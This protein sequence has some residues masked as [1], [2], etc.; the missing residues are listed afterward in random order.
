MVIRWSGER[1]ARF[2]TLSSY[3]HLHA[4]STISLVSWPHLKLSQRV[5]PSTLC[6]LTFSRYLSVTVSWG[7]SRSLPRKGICICHITPILHHRHW[8]PIQQRIEY[9][10]LLNTFKVPQRSA[11]KYLIDLIYGLQPSFFYDLRRS[12]NWILMSTLKCFRK[13]TKGYRSF[14]VAVLRIWNSLPINIRSACTTSCF[15]QKLKT[16]S[17]SKAI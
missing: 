7:T 6:T 8:L 3:R 16:S 2:K 9:K 10:I 15:K 1:P 13:V 5:I 17:F 4:L 14:M 11:P 12:N